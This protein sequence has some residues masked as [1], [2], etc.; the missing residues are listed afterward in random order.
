MTSLSTAIP[1]NQQRIL[2]TLLIGAGTLVIAHQLILQPLRQRRA[3]LETD[4]DIAIQ[5]QQ[6]LQRAEQT[7]TTLNQLQAPLPP[8]GETA[9]VLHA[10]SALAAQHQVTVAGM[11]PSPPQPAGPYTR[12]AVVVQAESP[13]AR[14]VPFLDAVAHATPPMQ[15]E[16]L[17]L[18][19]SREVLGVPEDL[20][21]IPLTVRMTVTTLLRE[22]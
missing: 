7:T 1:P 16:Q 10:V 20:T 17:D 18:A 4:L 8:R 3:A 21:E 6:L 14:L 22:D 2:A 9:A 13:Y 15:V 19:P 5:R 12:F 11:T